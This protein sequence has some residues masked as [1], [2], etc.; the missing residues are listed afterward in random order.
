MQTTK[1]QKYQKGDHVQVAKDLGDMMSHFTCDCEAV[2]IGS[3]GDQYGG[4]NTNL[5][6]IHIKGSGQHSWYCENQLELI[7]ASRIDLL[8]IWEQEE[9][10]ESDMKADLGWIFENGNEVLTSA[11]GSTVSSLANCLGITN[12]WGSRG[13][14]MTYYANATRILMLAQPFLETGDKDSWLAWCE[15]AKLGLGS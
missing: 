3:Y 6:T 14:G 10:K 8:D 11:H 5:Y 12:L 2:V 9:E 4:G 15:K 7:E 1:E 13:E